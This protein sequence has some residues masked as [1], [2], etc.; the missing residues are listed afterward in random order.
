MMYGTGPRL[1]AYT[2]R[3]IFLI[4]WLVFGP[5][6]KSGSVLQTQRS[7][8]LLCQSTDPLGRVDWAKHQSLEVFSPLACFCLPSTGLLVRMKAYGF[9]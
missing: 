4:S 1:D 7:I 8:A 5:N 9:D 2:M 3:S 6:L